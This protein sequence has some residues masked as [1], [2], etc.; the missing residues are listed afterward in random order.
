MTRQEQHAAAME[1]AE[2]VRAAM[3]GE[4]KAQAQWLA[5]LREYEPRFRAM[6]VIKPTFQQLKKTR[7]AGLEKLA[8]CARELAAARERV[9]LARAKKPKPSQAQAVK[10]IGAR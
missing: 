6:N 10:L 2:Q 3:D 5:L 1:K 4:E 7:S 8:Q 9:A